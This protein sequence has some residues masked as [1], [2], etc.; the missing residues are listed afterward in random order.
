MTAEQHNLEEATW[1]V[2]VVDSEVKLY[3]LALV[4]TEDPE[5]AR[6]ISGLS[7]AA[8]SSARGWLAGVGV[9]RPDGT[10]DTDLLRSAGKR[11]LTVAAA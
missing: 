10:L 4:R 7:A 5:K 3:L 6:E 11:R 9:L 1:A 8:A 2:D